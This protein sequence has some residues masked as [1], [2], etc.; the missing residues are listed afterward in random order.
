M[1]IN[2]PVLLFRILS[3]DVQRHEGYLLIYK[4]VQGKLKPCYLR[5]I[6]LRK[7]AGNRNAGWVQDGNLCSCVR[8]MLITEMEV[9]MKKKS[10]KNPSIKGNPDRTWRLWDICFRLLCCWFD[11]DNC[12]AC[13]ALKGLWL[14]WSIFHLN[15]ITPLNSKVWRL[16]MKSGGLLMVSWYNDILLHP[17]LSTNQTFLKVYINTLRIHLIL[18]MA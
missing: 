8:E 6:E 4:R 5:Y 1:A 16:T 14:T 17:Q 2:T 7:T 10:K 13:F 11:W 9:R 15:W 3:F 18:V 12:D